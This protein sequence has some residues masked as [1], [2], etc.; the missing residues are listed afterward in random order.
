MASVNSSLLGRDWVG[1]FA[2]GFQL[3]YQIN[4][5]QQ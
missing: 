3:L 4:Q 1:W 2:G 5:L